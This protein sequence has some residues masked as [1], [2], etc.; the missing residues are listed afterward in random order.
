MA[1]TGSRRTV[2]SGLVVV[3]SVTYLIGI[4]PTGSLYATSYVRGFID[5][6][7]N[8]GAEVEVETRNPSVEL[9]RTEPRAHFVRLGQYLAEPDRAE[10]PVLFYG[11][12][13]DIS[14]LVGVCPEDYKLDDLMYSEFRRP[15]AVYLEENPGALIVI[16]T[17]DY[18]YL[19]GLSS[20]IS[21]VVDRNLT[22]TKKLGRWLSTVH[23][24]AANVQ[25]QL[26]REARA[27]LTGARLP[28]T[29][30]RSVEFGNYTVLEPN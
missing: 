6:M 1:V 3:A 17:R 18:E 7:T 29:H 9:E 20:A 30:R 21:P 2:A 15:E 26:H 5:T 11:P 24:D 28:I 22:P 27:R 12:A 13:W 25:N 4:A 10:L 14:P 23:Y 19:Y 16:R 8:R